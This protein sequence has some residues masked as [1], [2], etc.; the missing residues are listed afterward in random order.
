[1][2]FAVYFVLFAFVPLEVRHALVEQWIDPVIAPAITLGALLGL[3]VYGWRALDAR[4]RYQQWLDDHLSN[5]EEFRLTWLRALLAVMAGLG[6][7]WLVVA[8]TDRFI[9]PL[10]YFDEFPFYLLQAGVA[11][12]L[13][14]LAWREA[15]LRYPTPQDDGA[16][17]PAPDVG[18]APNAPAEL[19]PRGP[20]WAALGAS[21]LAAM[22]EREW[23]RDPQLTLGALA[24]HL[25]T[26]SSYVSKALNQ[27]VGQGFNEC[28]NRL[29]VDAV[30]AQLRAGSTRDLVQIG[31]DCGFNSKASFQR[32]F[33]L[34]MQQT[35]SAYR[36]AVRREGAAQVQARAG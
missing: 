13:G 30:A 10:S 7:V 9:R 28:V 21:Y 11:W 17:A 32:A 19:T 8:V 15:E 16:L 25:A 22:R 36:E 14:L 23:W 6:V 18:D 27:G 4:R 1:V 24:R 5:R 35:P 34:Y 20:D 3:A 31:F 2:H 29:R 12:V 33:V 26:N